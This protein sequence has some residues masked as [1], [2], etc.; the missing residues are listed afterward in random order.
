M[1]VNHDPQ[2]TRA[3]RTKMSEKQDPKLE[4]F[5]RELSAIFSGNVRTVND[6]GGTDGQ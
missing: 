6:I 5:I 2:V 1:G 4:E 3:R